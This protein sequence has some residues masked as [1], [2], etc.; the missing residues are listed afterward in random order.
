MSV[1]TLYL[2]GPIKKLKIWF[3]RV[4]NDLGIQVGVWRKRYISL[5]NFILSRLTLPH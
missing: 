1:D 5:G 3:K 4:Q 2:G